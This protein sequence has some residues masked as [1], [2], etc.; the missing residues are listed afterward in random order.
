MCRAQE[1]RKRQEWSLMLLNNKEKYAWWQ[2]Q[3]ISVEHQDYERYKM[4]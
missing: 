3:L 4:H 2:L 1:S